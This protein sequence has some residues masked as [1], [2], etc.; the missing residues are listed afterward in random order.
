MPRDDYLAVSTDQGV[1]CGIRPEDLGVECFGVDAPT[2][3][4]VALKSLSFHSRASFRGLSIDGDAMSW[5]DE[6]EKWSNLGGSWDSF[7]TNSWWE[8]AY[9][10][11]TDVQYSDASGTSSIPEIAAFDVGEYG[12]TTTWIGTD[13]CFRVDDAFIFGQ[14]SEVDCGGP[15]QPIVVGGAAGNYA[16]DEDGTIHQL[17]T[18]DE[19]MDRLSCPAPAG[20][21]KA[22][23]RGGNLTCAIRKSG[24]LVC[25]QARTYQDDWLK[26]ISEPYVPS[27]ES[28]ND[29]TQCF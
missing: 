8:E 27:G 23:A 13:G 5:W 16:L 20:E 19:Y 9:Q 4:A 18:V 29:Y 22:L 6:E 25:W 12:G 26:A 11:G 21:F 10:S 2:P 3:P 7:T 15:F 28:G 1:V 24:A 14:F 17:D